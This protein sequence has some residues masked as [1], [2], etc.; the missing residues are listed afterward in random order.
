MNIMCWQWRLCHLS[1]VV[2]SSNWQQPIRQS[3]ICFLAQAFMLIVTINCNTTTLK[4]PIWF[5]FIQRVIHLLKQIRLF[6]IFK[7]ILQFKWFTLL[8]PKSSSFCLTLMYMFIVSAHL[9][10]H[11]S[12]QEVVDADPEWQ[13]E[14]DIGMHECDKQSCDRWNENEGP[15]Q[16]SR[17]KFIK[18]V[19]I[20]EF[21]PNT[22]KCI[23]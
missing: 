17:H 14:M 1:A 22:I 16:I 9:P 20:A 5:F 12:E 10:H 18:H 11:C 2:V 8:H 21:S 23:P 13:I 6:H 4:S 19:W 7:N 15:G 3:C